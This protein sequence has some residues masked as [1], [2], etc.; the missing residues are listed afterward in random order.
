MRRLRP[1]D[2][3]QKGL[4]PAV[5][6]PSPRRCQ[7]CQGDRPA[8]RHGQ[9]GLLPEQRRR[10]PPAVLRR[11]GHHP[12]RE[13][14]PAAQAQRQRTTGQAPARTGWTPPSR[15]VQPRLV[16][17]V[18]RDFTRANEEAHAHAGNP[19]LAW[20][21]YLAYR[22][23]EARG[24]RP[25]VHAQVRRALGLVLAGFADGDEVRCSQLVPAMRALGIGADR[26]AEVLDEMGVLVNDQRPCFEDWLERKLNGLA[27]GIGHSVEAW[28][29]T[30]RDGGPAPR[31]GTRPRPP[32]T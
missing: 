30:L 6:E 10:L 1:H 11:D 5:L 28:V 25:K 13:D 9:G 22:R 4:L 32:R 7:G 26:V 31:P 19:W 2:R 15:W 16:D 29:R 18:R 12:R 17:D 24:W 27:E 23:G 3:D 21:H 20:A 8:A 14:D